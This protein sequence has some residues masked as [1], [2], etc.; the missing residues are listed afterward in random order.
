[1]VRTASCCTAC[2]QGRA[3]AEG[4]YIS[5]AGLGSRSQLPASCTGQ[6]GILPPKTQGRAGQTRQR[7]LEHACKGLYQM[8]G[9]QGSEWDSPVPL[10]L[11]VALVHGRAAG[12]GPH[13]IDAVA[14]AVTLA[15]ALLP[16]SDG[17]SC[18]PHVSRRTLQGLRTHRALC[19]LPTFVSNKESL[20]VVGRPCG[21]CAG[22]LIC[23]CQATPIRA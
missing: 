13:G 12:S 3:F 19:W 21:S 4:S 18:E 10:G 6:G 1:M 20:E 7:V 22:K 16:R 23:S 2:A 14:A 11:A 8:E 15:A 9:G 5:G 17:R